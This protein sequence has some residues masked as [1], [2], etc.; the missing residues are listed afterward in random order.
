VD[1]EDYESDADMPVM[2]DSSESEDED[3][4]DDTTTAA[5]INSNTTRTLRAFR[6]MNV[7]FNLAADFMHAKDQDNVVRRSDDQMPF[8]T[9]PMT[10]IKEMAQQ[11]G[12][13]RVANMVTNNA[14]WKRPERMK[15][16]IELGLPYCDDFAKEFPEGSGDL[17]LEILRSAK[18]RLM[19]AASLPGLPFDRL[20][21]VLRHPFSAKLMEDASPPFSAISTSED[22]GCG[23]SSP[24]TKPA[25]AKSCCSCQNLSREMSTSGV[26]PKPADIETEM[27]KHV[28]Q[29]REMLQDN[30]DDDLTEAI[31]EIRAQLQ[32]G[33]VNIMEH[34]EPN[35]MEL[36]NDQFK[37]VKIE[38]A[39]D[40]GAVDH[41]MNR[42]DIPGYDV[43]PS[44][45]SMRGL[46]F[47]AA[48][49][50]TIDNEGEATLNLLPDDTKVPLQSTFQIAAVSRPLYSAS[51][52]A[53]MGCTIN[54]DKASAV[55]SKN[56]RPIAKFVR[57]RGLYLCQMTL[58]A[59]KHP[60]PQQAEAVFA[61]QAK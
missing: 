24:L 22:R 12:Y 19:E 18:R 48:N 20:P 36:D 35:L 51:K 28:R 32:E 21:E 17:E 40:S 9:I 7:R 26:E 57:K 14:P 52:V 61:R 39:L 5:W 27:E 55:V 49:G 8:P 31:A 54:I 16:I 38:I 10:A 23:G 34:A 3:N 11:C 30:D 50:D 25:A 41:V 33:H 56:G 53:D 29:I 37:E 60:I 6:K 45:G 58:R 46:H 59:P 43:H 4:D 15:L 42:C 1:D 47:V 13:K 2:A 44:K